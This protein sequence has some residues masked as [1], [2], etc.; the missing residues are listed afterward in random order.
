MI[1]HRPP[2]TALKNFLLLCFNTKVV[3]QNCIFSL[4]VC[5]APPKTKGKEVGRQAIKR[6]KMLQSVER[7]PVSVRVCLLRLQYFME[8]VSLHRQFH[9]L[10]VPQILSIHKE[11]S[12][13]HSSTNGNE[14]FLEM[15]ERK[16]CG[17]AETFP[18]IYFLQF[19]S[20]STVSNTRLGNQQ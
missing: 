8:C 11:P 13:G 14:Q 5:I 2:V 1:L 17:H 7:K 9:L 4:G 6:C 10:K 20:T 18:L 19:I 16:G 3:Q 15:R 12:D